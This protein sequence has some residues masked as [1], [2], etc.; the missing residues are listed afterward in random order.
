MRLARAAAITGLSCACSWAWLVND[1]RT[2][3]S[4]RGL[5]AAER[6]VR[7]AQANHSPAP[8]VAAAISWLARGALDS[9]QL[10]KADAYASESRTLALR[11]L[12]VRRLDADPWLPT[13][14]GASIEVHGKVLAARG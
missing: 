13:A 9:N 11:T 10:S 6:E 2:I 5:A 4:E 7:A 3:M 1:V 12:G 8:E 14:V